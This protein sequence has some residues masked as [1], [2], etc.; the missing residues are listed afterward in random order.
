MGTTLLPLTGAA[1]LAPGVGTKADGGSLHAGE[2]V[3]CGQAGSGNADGN[4]GVTLV[5]IHE[6]RGLQQEFLAVARYDD[7]TVLV[8][9]DEL[10]RADLGA[11]NF[12][13]DAPT[14]GPAVGMA[15]GEAAG[16][17]L[18]AGRPHLVEIADGPVSD[19]TNA[20]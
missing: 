9:M 20:A 10:T 5:V 16:Q 8:G 17:S 19:G 7:E 18:E 14:Q 15:D 2:K 11:E 3:R 12:D 1:V 4:H 13:F 6:A